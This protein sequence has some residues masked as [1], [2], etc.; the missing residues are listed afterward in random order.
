MQYPQV[1]TIVAKILVNTWTPVRFFVYCFE[2]S[3]L[4]RVLR[5]QLLQRLN[6]RCGCSQIT[7]FVPLRKPHVN[8]GQKVVCFRSSNR[9][10]TFT[11]VSSRQETDAP[12]ILQQLRHPRRLH[13]AASNATG[14]SK[15]MRKTACTFL[16][17][18]PSQGAFAGSPGL[19]IASRPT[20]S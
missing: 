12:L 14:S 15:K 4:Y 8:G 19:K 10:Q 13:N 18:P 11:R 7:D 17:R 3:G 6:Q 5:K 16:L 1:C 20:S 9:Q 2:D